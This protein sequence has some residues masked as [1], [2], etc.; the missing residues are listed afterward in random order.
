MSRSRFFGFGNETPDNRGG[1]FFETEQ[2]QFSLAPT[3]SY[4]FSPQLAIF[5]GGQI[6]FSSTDDDEDTLLNQLQPYGV[7]DF[8]QLSFNLGVEVDT[9]DRTKLY[10]PGMYIR[11]KGSVTPE[12]W[13]VDDGTFGAI[14]GEVAGYIGL[15]ERLLLALRVSGRNVFGTFP[16][17]EAAYIWWQRYRAGP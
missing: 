7:G 4:A 9:R 8:G 1:D 3:V 15:T 2:L 13:D 10:G 16:F 14:E 6:K 17:Q 11:L 12:V 5:A